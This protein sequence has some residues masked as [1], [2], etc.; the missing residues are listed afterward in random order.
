[1]AIPDA[2]VQHGSS[3]GEIAR[4][5]RVVRSLVERYQQLRSENVALRQALEESEK[6]TRALEHERLDVNQ[7]R[8]DAVKRIGDLVSQV[9]ALDARLASARFE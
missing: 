6:R 4:L 7:R 9:D 5:D 8:Q 2:T 3:R 1:M